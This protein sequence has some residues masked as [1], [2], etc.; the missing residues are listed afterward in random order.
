M[1]M[2]IPTAS[3]FFTGI[4]N[5]I[6]YCISTPNISWSASN[7]PATYTAEHKKTIVGQ[8]PAQ[9]VDA[10][11]PPPQYYYSNSTTIAITQNPSAFNPVYST[12]TFSA[13]AT[14]AQ[15]KTTY[16]EGA[17][18]ANKQMRDG[19]MYDEQGRNFECSIVC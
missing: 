5:Q 2:N 6:M 12:S 1:E 17:N 14:A 10:H 11:Q 4:P 13:A 8:A 15:P 7:Q 19:K 9:P 16:S 18:E 3:P